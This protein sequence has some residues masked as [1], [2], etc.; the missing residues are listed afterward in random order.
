MI[1]QPKNFR[2]RHTVQPRRGRNECCKTPMELQNLIISPE[3][4]VFVNDPATKHSHHF[5]IH[6]RGRNECCKTPMWLQN[7]IIH[8]EQ[9]VFVNDPA[10]KYSHESHTVQQHS[11]TK[12]VPRRGT[13]R[14]YRLSSSFTFPWPSHASSDGGFT[15]LF[16]T[17][18]RHRL[19][20]AF[21]KPRKN[22]KGIRPDC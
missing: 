14:G 21:S 3:Q 13:P 5:P 18:A 11:L 17:V 15:Y 19:C 10:T 22:F 16:S 20:L 6:R 4:Q 12:S 2:R 8:P 9:Q 7:K 1:L